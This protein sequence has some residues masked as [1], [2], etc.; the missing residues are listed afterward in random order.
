[1]IIIHFL[2]VIFLFILFS[3]TYL[4]IYFYRFLI[5]LLAYLFI[6]L[7]NFKNFMFLQGNLPLEFKEGGTLLGR[8]WR[9]IWNWED[10]FWIG[11]FKKRISEG[12]R[13]K[14]WPGKRGFFRENSREA[15]IGG[16]RGVERCTRAGKRRLQPSLCQ[17]LLK[18]PAL[19]GSGDGQSFE[20]KWK[21]GGLWSSLI[22]GIAW[23]PLHARNFRLCN[24]YSC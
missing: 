22:H 8:F 17:S 18:G 20:T 1:M 5:Y 19:S 10:C 6:Q 4:F 15:R 12:R 7:F 9:G 13:K 14:E 3:L 24:T 23:C 16:L 2:L 11:G 21:L